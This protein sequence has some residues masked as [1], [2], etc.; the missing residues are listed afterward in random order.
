MNTYH[1]QP[2]KGGHHLLHSLF[3]TLRIRSGHIHHHRSHPIFLLQHSN[4]PIR[5]VLGSV[6]PNSDIGTS[7]SER[8]CDVPSDTSSAAGNERDATLE[9]ERAGVKVEYKLQSLFKDVFST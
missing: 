5:F 2:T 8:A 4:G 9:R 6:K 1:V 7:F 3:H